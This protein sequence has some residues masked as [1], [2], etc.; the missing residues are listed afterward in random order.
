MRA[1]Q[2]ARQRA[3]ACRARIGRDP[4]GLLERVTR[5][6]LDIY[7]I[8]LIR[9]TSTFLEGGH[10]EISPAEGCLFYNE[11][12]DHH[13]AEKQLVILHELGHLELHSRLQRWCDTPD[14]VY[15]T[16]Y[17]NDGAPALAR[18]NR[19]SRE[20]AE[21]NAFAMEFL[22]PSHDLLQTWRRQPQT[23]IAQLAERVGV[24]VAVVQTQLAEA[25]YWHV[26]SEPTSP[27]SPPKREIDCDSSQLDAAT[28]IGSP[29]LV[30][31]GPGTGENG[32]LDPPRPISAR[33][34]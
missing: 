9:A 12:L 8:E 4:Q 2:H 20:E 29:V 28:C 33:Y 30:D 24:P 27:S 1:L 3:R 25:L 14:P 17:L 31:A 19:R 6:L 32:N 21:A 26:F 34:M 10:A 16:M 13:L 11:Q 5:Y 15:G 22:C 23:R 18:Y 7:G